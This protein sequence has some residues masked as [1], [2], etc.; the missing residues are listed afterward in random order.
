MYPFYLG[1]DLHLKRTYMVLMNSSGEVID[2]RRILNNELNQYLE[3][4]VPHSTYAVMEATRN[5][6]FMY[7]QLVHHVERVDI[8][9]PKE[10]VAISSAAV[11]ADRIDAKVLANLARL[12]YLPVAYAAPKEIRDLRMGVRHRDQLVRLR[13]QAKNRIHAILASY[14]LV[15]SV[16]DL[17]GLK[18]RQFLAEVLEV[19]LRSAARRVVQDNLD[20]IEHLNQQIKALESEM[21]LTPEQEQTIRLLKTVPGVGRVIA[22]TILAEIG[23]IQRF[24]SPKALCNWAGLTP[25]VRSSDLLVRHGRISKQGSSLLRAA[26]TRAATIASR[27]SKRWYLVHDGLVLRCGKQAAK[28][29]VA[30]RLLTVVYFM[31]K[32]KQPYQENYQR[33]QPNAR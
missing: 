20:L 29:A 8:A 12:N 10:L 7:D 1:I 3:K 28:V 26:M 15:P 21:V 25:K 17:F 2:E 11:K 23:D 24:N 6:A 19:E 32:R 14:N 9:H 22:I 16:S 5:W 33:C 30:R 4:K 31:L 27:T 13:T 18:G